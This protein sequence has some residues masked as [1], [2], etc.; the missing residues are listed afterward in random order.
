[1]KLF[2]FGVDPV[3]IIAV[4]AVPTGIIAI[5][6][7]ARGVIAIGQAAFGVIAFG[8]LAVGVFWAMGQLVL[9]P[10][11]GPAQLPIGLFGGLDLLR[12]FDPNAGALPRRARLP[13][14]QVMIGSVVLAGILAGWWY[15][16]GAY[17]VS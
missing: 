15:G 4:G 13:T 16:V 17:L 7:G 12:L 10:F 14:W 11:S 5:G 1:M 6:E 8:Q 9:A 3:G 2:A